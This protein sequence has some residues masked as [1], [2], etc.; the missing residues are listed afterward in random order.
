MRFS[1]NHM[2]VDLVQ[3]DITELDT[4]A[5][6]NAANSSLILGAGVAGAIRRKGGPSIQKECNKIGRCEVGGAV[7][8]GAGNLKARHVIHAVGPRKGDRDA[9]AK[10][11]SAVRSVLKLAEDHQLESVALPAISTGI[12]A[13]PMDDCARIMA[14]EVIDYSFEARAYLQHV[15]ICLYGEAAYEAF[16]GIF[17]DTISRVNDTYKD[18]TLVL[19]VE[20]D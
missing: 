14:N 13:F 7:I 9:D 6:T 10:L 11:A 17:R 4:D 16:R 19:D 3:G 1:V 18:S 2:T 20:D 12:F 5:I 8:T 15:V